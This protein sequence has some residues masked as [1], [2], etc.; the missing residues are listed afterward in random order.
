MSQ[1]RPIIV[2]NWKMNFTMQDAS[3]YL[4]ELAK[5]V[6][7]RQGIDVILAPSIFTLQS[8]IL[9]INRRQ[10]KL[11]A[12]NFYWRDMGSFTG[13]VSIAQLRGIVDYGIVGHSER[14]YVFSETDKDIR[15]KVQASLRSGI[16]PI[17][18][19]GETISEKTHGETKDV[20]A[21]QLIGGLANVT[22]EEISD[23]VIAYEPVW[24]IGTGENAMPDDVSYAA[25]AIRNQI[26]QLYGN[27]ASESVRV[28]YGGS[29]TKDS[30][31]DYLKIPE[32]DGLML[33]KVSLVANDFAEIVEKL[34][35]IKN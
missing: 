21:D 34:N 11:A 13:E 15:A 19:V 26:K 8:L 14:R 5:I 12:Q 6:K 28:I 32:I 7:V 20:L 29:I 31:A 3:L 1:R 18:C 10:F 17:L 9:Q 23:C 27:K 22:S 2:G 30:A 4:H 16:K 25:K 35:E 24:A 33:G